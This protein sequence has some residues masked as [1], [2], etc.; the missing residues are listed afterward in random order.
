MEQ[1]GHMVRNGNQSGCGWGAATEVVANVE[2]CT[3]AI[4]IRHCPCLL[5]TLK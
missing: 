1:N 2:Q 3:S 5:A 4:T